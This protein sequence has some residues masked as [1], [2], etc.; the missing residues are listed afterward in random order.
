MTRRSKR[1]V[2]N[3]LDE[4]DADTG[5]ENTSFDVREGV[6]EPFVTYEEPADDGDDLP[7]G[8]EVA[9][10]IESDTATYHVVRETDAA[11][12]GESA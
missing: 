3:W 4:F 1:E 9:E 10:V 7:P 8:C 5:G 2:E 6:S 11:R 12:G